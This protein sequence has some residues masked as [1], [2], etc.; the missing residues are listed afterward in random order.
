MDSREKTVFH[1]ELLLIFSIFLIAF[2]IRLV[3]LNQIKSNPLF[4]PFEG[5]LDEFLYDAWAKEIAFKDFIGK[6]I[7]WGLPLYPYFLG[8]VYFLFGHD[9]LIARLIQFAI[10][11]INCVLLYFIGKR[12]FNKQ[13]GI[14]ASLL[15]ALYSPGIFYEGFLSASFLSIF[16]NCVII[17]LILSVH[18]KP[19]FVKWLFTGFLIGV[20]GLA[21][22]TIFLFIP[23]LIWWIFKAY[24]QLDLKKKFSY[25]VAIFIGVFFII[26]IITFRNYAV[27]KDFVP[28]SWHNGITFYTGNNPNSEGTFHLPPSIGRGM[29]SAMRNSR[30]EAEK[31]LQRKLKPSE[32]SGYWFK[33][34]IL[35]IKNEPSKYC[36]SLF[37]KFLLFWN[38]H[39]ISD[40]VNMRLFINRFSPL[41]Q[42]PLFNF[43]VIMPFAIL[44]MVLTFKSRRRPEVSLIYMLVLSHM[45]SVM[46][47]FVNGRYRLPIV[48]FLMLFSSFAVVWIIG[49]IKSGTIYKVVLCIPLLIILILFENISLTITG[50]EAFYNNLGIAYKKKGMYKEAEKEYKEAIRIKPDYDTPHY[51]LGL[52]YRDQGLYTKAIEYFEKALSIN[53]DFIDARD[54]LEG[55]RPLR[56]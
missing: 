40:V 17:L 46:I 36:K 53:P 15:L 35:F 29:K 22:A 25:T 21:G 33:Q 27:G 9:L 11:A 10:G 43:S 42:L 20:S 52:L 56:N 45:I 4:I 14:V 34:G 1:K 38:G 13:V 30:L 16:L 2:V 18:Q 31:V 47:Y 5:G 24:K 49:Q 54:K 44:G 48:P 26:G 39:E 7:F 37:D 23:F 51:N 19:G 32:V 55:C 6:E 12:I 3:Y 28:I 8:A 41:L 50:P